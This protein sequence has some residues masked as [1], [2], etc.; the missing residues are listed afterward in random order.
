MR[1]HEL[2]KLVGRQS[3]GVLADLRDAGYQL[4][5]LSS[6]VE[7]APIEEQAVIA[8]LIRER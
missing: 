6:K 7:L 8:Y 4:K 2:A 3:K 5:S 1:V